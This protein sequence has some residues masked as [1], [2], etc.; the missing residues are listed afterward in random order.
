MQHG[1]YF[2][3]VPGCKLIAMV[4]SLVAQWWVRPQTQ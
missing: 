3:Y 2:D 1:Y 4:S